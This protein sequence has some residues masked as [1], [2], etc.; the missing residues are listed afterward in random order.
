MDANPG[1]EKTGFNT[2]G[3]L[4]RMMKG[5]CGY[6]DCLNCKQSDCHMDN[7]DISAMLKRRRYRL[8]PEVYRQKQHDYRKKIKDSLPHCDE[9]D[10]CALVQAERE[11]YRRLCI[12]QMRL[13][14]QKVSNSPT[15]CKKRKE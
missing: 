5:D 14:E 3:Y 1:K 2:S 11:G 15:W 6:P 9:C 4:R 7:N 8:N 13:I 12:Y 10:D